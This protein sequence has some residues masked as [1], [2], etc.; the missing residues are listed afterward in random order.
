MC[1]W[2]SSLSSASVYSRALLRRCANTLRHPPSAH[3][4]P[5]HVHTPA[6]FPPRAL[7]CVPAFPP[8]SQPL[9]GPASLRPNM[10]HIRHSLDS[11]RLGS[12]LEPWTSGACIFIHLLSKFDPLVI[13]KVREAPVCTRCS[14]S[15]QV[16]TLQIP[17][18]S[19]TSSNV[20]EP[21]PYGWTLF[22]K[23]DG[24]GCWPH[25]AHG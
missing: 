13:L 17:A 6:P 14:E 3:A 20:E 8:F 16:C 5:P 18:V 4:A 24:N 11:E 12:F 23:Q 9:D 7:T 25:R 2:N 19:F 10:D 21:L 22:S 15:V 1:R